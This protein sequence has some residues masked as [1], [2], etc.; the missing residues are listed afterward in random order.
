MVSQSHPLFIGRSAAAIAW[1]NSAVYDVITRKF[2]WRMQ[3]L[4]WLIGRVPSFIIKKRLYVHP[5][6]ITLAA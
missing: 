5:I 1:V 3:K 6:S 2:G 4:R